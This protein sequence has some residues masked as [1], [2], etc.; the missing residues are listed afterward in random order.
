ML[1]TLATA[2]QA[3]TQVITS[4]VIAVLII[5]L[6]F[7]IGKIVDITLTKIFNE[8]EVDKNI[9]KIKKSKTNVGKVLP[10]S[11]ALIIYIISV[12]IA[13]TSIGIIGTVFTIAIYIILVILIGGIILNALDVIPNAL[14]Y[15]ALKNKIKIGDKIK[16]KLVEGKII[17]MSLLNTTIIDDQKNTYYLPNTYLGKEKIKIN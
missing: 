13:L 12:I 17:K 5:L 7:V 2:S 11:I 10:K 14:E 4:I 9:K 15:F 3:I 1:P 8:L 6:G 16:T